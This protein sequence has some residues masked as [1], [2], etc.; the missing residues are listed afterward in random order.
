MD[1]EEQGVETIVY[2]YER[3]LKQNVPKQMYFFLIRY[4]NPKTFVK[5]P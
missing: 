1:L 2:V 5:E 3:A 4:S